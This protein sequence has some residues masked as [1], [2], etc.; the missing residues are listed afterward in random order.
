MYALSGSTGVPAWTFATGSPVNCAAAFDVFGLMYVGTSAGVAVAVGPTGQQLWKAS[1]GGPVT[2]IAVISDVVDV[3]ASS[4]VVALT[5]A[6]V[7]LCPSRLV[8]C[9]Q[10]Q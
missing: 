10:S 6:T 3:A 9:P 2:S 8:N 5:A 4:D 1:V 7:L